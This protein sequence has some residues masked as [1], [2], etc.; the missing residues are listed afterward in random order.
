MNKKIDNPDITL[1][2]NESEVNLLL[3]SAAFLEKKI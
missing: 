2:A 3:E 1:I